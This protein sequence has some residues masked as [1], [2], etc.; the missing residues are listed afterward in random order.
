MFACIVQV[1]I[2]IFVYETVEC[3]WVNYLIPNLI[4]EDV[5]A[6]SASLKSIVQHLCDQS[7]IH[8]AVLKDK[9]DDEEEDD[10]DALYRHGHSTYFM[11]MAPYLFVSINVAK[12]HP[13]MLESMLVL[14][15]SSHL[16]GEISTKWTS[17]KVGLPKVVAA[18]DDEDYFSSIY[19]MRIFVL[20]FSILDF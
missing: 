6:A 18:D 12:E 15:Y 9:E 3:I 11:N 20:T 16:P 5:K 7:T 14:S 8:A 1:V 13:S 2:E 10:T 17:A 19:L 4:A